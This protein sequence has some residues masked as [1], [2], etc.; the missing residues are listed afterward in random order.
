MLRLPL[1]PTEELQ[2]LRVQTATHP[3]R[4]AGAD[5]YNIVRAS[6]AGV[7]ALARHGLGI[8]LVPRVGDFGIGLGIVAAP[9]PTR[10][11]YERDCT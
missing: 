5:A 2:Q 9:T 10:H 11:R 1:R 4:R 3:I 6:L 8:F 7:S